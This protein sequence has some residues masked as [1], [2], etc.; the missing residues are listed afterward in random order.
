M[1]LWLSAVA[2]LKVTLG[3]NVRPQDRPQ[4]HSP[5]R[6]LSKNVYSPQSVHN[7][8]ATD[9]MQQAYAFIAGLVLI[10]LAVWYARSGGAAKMSPIR[11]FIIVAIIATIVALAS[12]WS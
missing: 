6:A 10:A 8:G 5:R 11:D 4:G 3:G 9:R 7:R 12:Y 2:G 1:L